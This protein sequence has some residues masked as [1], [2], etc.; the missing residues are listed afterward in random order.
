[1]QFW[2]NFSFA[3]TAHVRSMTLRVRL[4]ETHPG[5]LFL[6]YGS[7][8][9]SSP[10]G[11]SFLTHFGNGTAS[12]TVDYP[13]SGPRATNYFATIVPD[14]S[15]N[16]FSFSASVTFTQFNPQITVVGKD[17]VTVDSNEQ[18]LELQLPGDKLFVLS[19]LPADVLLAFDV[20]E[21]ALPSAQPEFSG[22]FS[23]NFSLGYIP[24]VNRT[25]F[26]SLATYAG[27]VTC[28][29][30]ELEPNFYTPIPYIVWAVL[31]V[32]IVAVPCAVVAGIFFAV[33]K[34]RRKKDA[35][36]L[37]NEKLSVQYDSSVDAA[38]EDAM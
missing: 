37:E 32:L 24:R 25:I 5:R 15:S 23:G 2:F 13:V 9:I 35:A 3:P 14:D 10:F 36:S 26:M 18:M 12:I 16:L 31:M 29:V 27:Q 38:D 21:N 33:S 7:Y 30:I 22:N 1:M 28:K 20:R 6:F 4:D 17:P 8:F 19:C 34:H 11:D